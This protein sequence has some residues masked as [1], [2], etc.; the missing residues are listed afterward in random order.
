M[1]KL[2]LLGAGKIGDAIIHLLSHTG[3]YQLTVADSDLAR[4]DLIPDVLVKKRHVDIR[5]PLARAIGLPVHIENSG[6]AC[7]PRCGDRSIGGDNHGLATDLRDLTFDCFGPGERSVPDPVEY[8]RIP[9]GRL[10]PRDGRLEVRA[11]IVGH[12]A[13]AVVVLQRENSLS[14]DQLQMWNRCVFSDAAG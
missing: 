1:T 4:L 14:N 12:K 10:I 3:D 6:R 9:R 7:A 13:A 5:E 11:Q 8:V 2:T